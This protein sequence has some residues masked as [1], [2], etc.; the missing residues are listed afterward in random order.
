MHLGGLAELKWLGLSNTKVTDDGLQH[1]RGLTEL[2]YLCLF[3][4]HVTEDG[5]REVRKCLPNCQILWDK[6][7]TRPSTH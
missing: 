3:G 7:D 2:R 6:E 5:I 4:T 1:I